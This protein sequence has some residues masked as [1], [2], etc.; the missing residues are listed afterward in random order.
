MTANLTEER[1]ALERTVPERNPYLSRLWMID[2]VL[3]LIGIVAGV[4]AYLVTANPYSFVFA[5]WLLGAAVV[6]AIVLLLFR[7]WAWERRN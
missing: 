1:P 7:A 2:G 3:V 5:L 6:L 4:G